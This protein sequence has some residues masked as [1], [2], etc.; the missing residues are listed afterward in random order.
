MLEDIAT[1]QGKRVAVD[2]SGF[3]Q[4]LDR[5]I[6]E[7]IKDPLVQLGR[8]A[9]DHGIET[10]E[11]RL[12]AGKSATA[13]VTIRIVR[14]DERRLAIEVIDDGRGI[15][16]GAVRDAAN[17]LRLVSADDLAAMS[18]E[19]L[20]ALAFRTGLS[21]ATVVT[22]LSGHGLGLAIVRDRIEAIG[23]HV[24][25]NSTPGGGVTVR[26]LVPMSV[27]AFRGLVV[28]A[29]GQRFLLPMEAV[30]A[31]VRR[32]ASELVQGG[33]GRTL[34]WQSEA[35]PCAL[36]SEVLDLPTEEAVASASR[37]RQNAVIVNAGER[38]GA[39]LVDVVGSEQSLLLKPL[40]LPLARVRHILAVAVGDDGEL[41]PVLRTADLLRAL[42]LNKDGRPARPRAIRRSR[43]KVLIVDD[44]VTTRLM[45]QSL[46]EAA[47]YEVHLAADGLEALSVLRQEPID[48]VV[49]DVDMPRLN[50]FEL[51]R[52]MRREPHLAEMP[53]ILVTA[54][55]SRED[56]EEGLRAGANAYVAKSTF[57]QTHLLEIVQRLA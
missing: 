37:T 9:V 41:I 45:E 47:G 50:G 49:S 54:L 44:S 17:R 26:M 36:L 20:L 52:H 40:P 5:R 3:D 28:E 11:A 16:P 8:N 12:A 22:T 30:V 21:T 51:T 24:E 6:L 23:G 14:H 4:V 7:A 46:F 29:S 38:R 57:D 43:I 18:P 34:T 56:K 48:L 32:P 1:E 2:I 33:L 19:R 13:R 53:I 31:V 27:D 55:E 25:L 39:L 35:L 15:N 42:S 10:V